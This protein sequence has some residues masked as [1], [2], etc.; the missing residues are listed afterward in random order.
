MPSRLRL[1]GRFVL[2]ASLLD[3]HL[4]TRVAGGA[5]VFAAALGGGQ[6]SGA[7]P[8]LRLR[9]RT[10]LPHATGGR[11]TQ[12][13]VAAHRSK[14][15]LCVAWTLAA[16]AAAGVSQTARVP[17]ELRTDRGQRTDPPTPDLMLMGFLS[18]RRA[19]TGLHRNQSDA[20]GR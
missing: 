7:V 13:G 5:G 20:D 6:R 18:R 17:E 4:Q 12:D 3:S 10:Q 11:Q 16:A 2:C 8:A 1:F 14:V 9:R 19:E 15:S